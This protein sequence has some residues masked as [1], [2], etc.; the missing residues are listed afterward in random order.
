MPESQRDIVSVAMASFLARLELVTQDFLENCAE[1]GNAA[2]EHGWLFTEGIR[3]LYSACR[4]FELGE[5]GAGG[6]DSRQREVVE[7]ADNGHGIV[8]SDHGAK[9]GSNACAAL[10][11][12]YRIRGKGCGSALLSA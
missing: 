12:D 4:L 9:T 11:G 5:G 6:D 2:S 7:L 10:R 3:G 1:R 8:S